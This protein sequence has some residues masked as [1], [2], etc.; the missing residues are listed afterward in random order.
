MPFGLTNAPE[1]FQ[2]TLDIAISALKW[3]SC[4]VYM[5]DVIVFSLDLNSH[6]NHVE[7]VLKTWS[8]TGIRLKLAKCRFFTDTVKYLGKVILPGTLEVDEARP[9]R[10]RSRYPRKLLQNF[11]PFWDFVMSTGVSSLTIGTLRHRLMRSLQRGNPLDSLKNW[12]KKQQT[13]ST[14]S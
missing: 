9:L 8:E 11:A 10:S 7:A 2:R 13:S 6:F 12:E 3:K 1:A 4:L 14:N 5:D